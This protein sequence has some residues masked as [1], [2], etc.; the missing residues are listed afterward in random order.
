MESVMSF[1][2]D[3]F[4]LLVGHRVNKWAVS[5]VAFPMT[6]N[7]DMLQNCF[8]G[9]CFKLNDM[10]FNLILFTLLIFRENEIFV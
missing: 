6:H 9:L 4:D 2:C 5:C 3:G 8:I 7:C 1:R 10:P